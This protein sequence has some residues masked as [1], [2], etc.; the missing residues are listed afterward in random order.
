MVLSWVELNP[1]RLV[2]LHL[3]QSCKSHFRV[4]ARLLGGSKHSLSIRV[5]QI[6]TFYMSNS[7]IL[8]QWITWLFSDLNNMSSISL[9]VWIYALRFE[10]FWWKN[11]TCKQFSSKEG[12]FLLN[13]LFAGP[14]NCVMYHSEYISYI[15]KIS[16]KLTFD[17]V[18]SLKTKP[19]GSRSK[20]TWPKRNKKVLICTNTFSCKFYLKNQN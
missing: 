11:S 6:R 10:S 15:I 2:W 5:V 16:D 13:L 14:N 20:P 4:C 7:S 1:L 17:K 19:L 18:L 3:Y 9:I 8:N 12:Y